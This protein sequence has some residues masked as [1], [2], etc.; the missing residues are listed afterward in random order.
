MGDGWVSPEVTLNNG[1]PVFSSWVS[2]SR[3]DFL[4]E[5]EVAYEILLSLTEQNFNI[6]RSVGQGHCPS[7]P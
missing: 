5:L 1:R 2:G 7:R 3:P 6:F 4:A